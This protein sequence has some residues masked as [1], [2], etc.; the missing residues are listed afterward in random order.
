MLGLESAN[1][2]V[3]SQLTFLK[4]SL[5]LSLF[6]EQSADHVASRIMLVQGM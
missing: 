2:I 6:F 4:L 5:H 3:D 1:E